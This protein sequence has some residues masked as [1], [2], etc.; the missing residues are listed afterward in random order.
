MKATTSADC[1]PTATHQVD[2]LCGYARIE[3]VPLHLFYKGTRWSAEQFDGER[4]RRNE[5]QSRQIEQFW[6]DAES[7]PWTEGTIDDIPD[8]DDDSYEKHNGDLE[9]AK[10]K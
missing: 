6:T 2:P 5:L 7:A 1:N 9:K 10:S 3:D 8:L 4:G